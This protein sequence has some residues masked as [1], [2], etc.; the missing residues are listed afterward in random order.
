[1][2]FTF[3]RSLGCSTFQDSQREACTCTPIQKAMGAVKD[4]AAAVNAGVQRIKQQV[5]DEL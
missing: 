3:T 2:F 1:M 5:Q 4:A